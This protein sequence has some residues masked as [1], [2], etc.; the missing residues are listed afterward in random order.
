[1]KQTRKQHRKAG[2]TT[3]G[4]ILPASA[5]AQLRLARWLCEQAAPDLADTPNC[6]AALEQARQLLAELAGD[7]RD[8]EA[9]TFLG[10]RTA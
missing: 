10:W 8:G 5:T 6:A 1:V 3:T 7:Y 2:T 4:L 9:A